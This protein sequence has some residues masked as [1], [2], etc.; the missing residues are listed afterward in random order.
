[1]KNLLISLLLLAFL[2]NTQAQAPVASFEADKVFGCTP[3]VVS[4]TNNSSPASNATYWWDFGNGVNSTEFEPQN[5]YT[6][7]GYYT[8]SLIVFANNTSDTL[9]IEE[10]IEAFDAFTPVFTI[11]EDT[12]GC[13]PYSVSFNDLTISDTPITFWHWDFGDGTISNQENPVHTYNYQSNFTV[14]LFVIDQNGCQNLLVKDDYI[15][16]FKPVANFAANDTTACNGSLDVN[17]TNLSEGEFSYLWSFGDGDQATIENP[18]HTYELGIFSPQLIITDAHN[19]KDTLQK[20]DYIQVVDLIAEFLTNK[21]TLCIDEIVEFTNTSELTSSYYWD[22]G[23]GN[24]S[25]EI[26]PTHS[27]TEAGDYNVTLFIENENS[28][29]SSFS[30]LINIEGVTANFAVETDFACELPAQIEYSNLSSNAQT[31]LWTFKDT[32][33]SVL[34]NPTITYYSEGYFDVTLTAISKHGCTDIMTIDNCIEMRKPHSYFTPNDWASPNDLK[35][36]LPL[37]IDFENKSY[38]S[39]DKDYIAGYEWTFGDGTTSNATNPTYTYPQVGVFPINLKVTTG[40]GCISEYGATAKIGTPQV[41]NFSTNLTDTVCS[42]QLVEFYDLSY[43]QNLINEYYWK[44]GDNKTSRLQNPKHVYVDTGYVNVELLAYYNGCPAKI[45]KDSL[46]YI[47]G[48]V[49]I[50]E[51]ENN[52]ENPFSVSFNSNA[53]NADEYLWDFG[54]GQTSTLQNPT[55]IYA[56]RGNYLV[57]VIANNDEVECAYYSETEVTVAKAEA[58]FEV[59]TNRACP[60]QEIIFR[61]S[62]SIDEQMFNYQNITGKYLWTFDDGNTQIIKPDSIVYSYPEKGVYNVKLKIID[63]HGCKDSIT[64]QIKIFKPDVSFEANNFYGCMPLNVN[65]QN[66]T[67]SDT[68]IAS[69]LWEFGDGTS[70]N[71]QNANH[72]YTS[73]NIYDVSLTVIDVIGCQSSLLSEDYIKAMQPNPE[74]SSPKRNLCVNDTALFECLDT[75]NIISYDWN[76]GNGQTANNFIAQSIFSN[77]GQFDVSLSVIDNHGCDSTLVL[78]NF[79]SVQDYPSPNFEADQTY[80]NCYPFIVNFTN[81]TNNPN[82]TEWYWNFG[83]EQG[84]SNLENP[85]HTFVKPNN[86]NVSLNAT[87]NYGCSN[88]FSIEN[89]ISV[90]GP[91]AEIVTKDTICQNTQT[92]LIAS[93]KSNVY[94]LQWFA[95]DGYSETNDTLAHIYQE[96]GLKYPVLLL[97]SDDNNTCDKYITTS[98][99]IHGLDSELD[100]ENSNTSGCVPFLSDFECV[101]DSAVFWKWNFGNGDI[102]YGQ[103]TQY[104]FTHSG[105]YKTELVAKSSFG[106]TDTTEI[107]SEIYALPK[108]NINNDTSICVDS[109]IN[110]RAQDG[111]EYYWYPN[112]FLDNNLISNPIAMPDSDITY[113]VEVINEHNC[114]NKDSV[115]I[116]VIQKPTIN[117]GDT[118]I[119]IGEQIVWDIDSTQIEN[120]SW[121][122][123]DGLSCDNCFSPTIKPLGQT[124]YTITYTDKNGCF[125]LTKDIFIDVEKKYSIDVPTAFSPNGDGINDV[126]YAKGWGV[127]NLVSFCIFNRYGEMVFETNDYNTGWDGTYKG[128]LQNVETYTYIV[129]AQGYNGQ[130]Q[131]KRGTIK[132]IK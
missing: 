9:I 34:E 18:Q 94:S 46:L 26:S 92:M 91:Y 60:S 100:I 105:F 77:S 115:K 35:G 13:S 42:S 51:H 120:I 123:S 22:F 49:V 70:S 131:T 31:Y 127:E 24:N 73:F 55:H 3:V 39:T 109:E 118:S 69:Y 82:V 130:T 2:T 53:I 48:A 41:A 10:Y 33:S 76:F 125:I 80:S 124:N 103:T 97:T 93:N 128:K 79:I 107:L 25:T 4:F 99:F 98:I 5:I 78:S 83:D 27:Y 29:S 74:F 87:T 16:V 38:Y 84:T 32:L 101:S 126:I 114:W 20:N 71:E 129:V 90:E 19:C 54:D 96:R 7:S 57:S 132:L 47:K 21:D 122:P 43:D 36:C 113:T 61:S 85:T 75:N 119:I 102:Q 30:K 88:T 58:N 62:S 86:F 50:A 106:C 56:E 72:T 95:G 121:Y 14:S 116:N 52:C 64:K 81:I 6:E 108:I 40:L 89:Y 37:V 15:S 111:E 63:T 59:S 66:N 44:F 68:T 8:V 104:E 17:F 65:F 110:L 11:E 12:I 1:M 112:D 67:I 117:L 28:C 45:T 23:D